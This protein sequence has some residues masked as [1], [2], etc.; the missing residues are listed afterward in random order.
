MARSLGWGLGIARLALMAGILRVGLV[1]AR[2]VLP[3]LMVVVWSVFVLPVLL[4]CMASLHLILVS[5]L[6][7]PKNSILTLT[8]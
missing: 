7:L 5:G 6:I 3:E 1:S 8:R 2:C 4:E